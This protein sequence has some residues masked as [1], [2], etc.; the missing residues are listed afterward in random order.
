MT[1]PIFH[2]A[3][4]ADPADD[5]RPHAL[6]TAPVAGAAVNIFDCNT[7]ANQ[8][9]FS[10]RLGRLRPYS[11]PTRCLDIAGANPAVVSSAKDLCAILM[12]L[13]G[14]APAG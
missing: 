7:G 2:E 1:R 5:A 10:D 4:Q 13:L 12:S 14:K 11:A 9:W 8:R 3:V 6:R